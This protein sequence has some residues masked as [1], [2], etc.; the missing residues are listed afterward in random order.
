VPHPPCDRSLDA[1]G[2]A[3][4]AA[5]SAILIDF[6]GRLHDTVEQIASEFDVQPTVR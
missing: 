3:A 1:V 6:L 2:I 4:D 5:P